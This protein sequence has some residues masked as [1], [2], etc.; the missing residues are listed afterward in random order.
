MARQADGAR[1]YMRMAQVGAGPGLGAADIRL[2][3]VF[4]DR[5]AYRRFVETGIEFSGK[6]EAVATSGGT[7][8][9]SQIRLIF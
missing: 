5:E 2:L 7:G 3:F 1:T 6:A 9:M 8:G 4:S